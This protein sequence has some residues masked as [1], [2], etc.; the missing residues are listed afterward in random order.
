[1]FIMIRMIKCDTNNNTG[2]WN[3]HKIIQK[4]SEQHTRKHDIKELQK[5][6]VHC[7]HTFE[8]NKVKVQNIC[9]GK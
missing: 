6:T 9:N 4:I 8:S 5:R 3:H 2:N 1:M 7:A